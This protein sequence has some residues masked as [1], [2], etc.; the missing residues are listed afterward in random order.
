[1]LLLYDPG[2]EVCVKI[3]NWL[4]GHGVTYSE[5]DIT[6]E[7]PTAQELV[8]WAKMG[9]LSLRSFWE[10]ETFSFRKLRLM[11]TTFL[12]PTEVSSYIMAGEPRF[13]AHP[14]LV[15]DDFVIVGSIKS[16]WQKA[17]RI[18]S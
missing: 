16:E 5:R 2:C 9:K 1:M 3:K 11:N 7:P 13:I 14:I 18:Q 6:A 15:G 17:L 12:G 4:D 8:D 10:R